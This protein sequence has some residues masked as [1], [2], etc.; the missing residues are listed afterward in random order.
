MEF[1]FHD[2]MKQKP[3]TFSTTTGFLCLSSLDN[4]GEKVEL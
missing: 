2:K 1:R 4:L 3:L